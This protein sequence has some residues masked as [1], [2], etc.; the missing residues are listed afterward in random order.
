MSS[1]KKQLEDS[2]YVVSKLPSEITKK[3]K[4]LSEVVN[5]IHLQHILSNT[6]AQQLVL[7]SKFSPTTENKATV[8][9]LRYWKKAINKKRNLN[10]EYYTDKE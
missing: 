2:I 7:L 6:G 4:V 9:E 5:S 8:G 10:E 1:L 3:K